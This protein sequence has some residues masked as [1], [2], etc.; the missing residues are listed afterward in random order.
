LQLGINPRHQ[1][2]QQLEQTLRIA[3][4]RF[5]KGEESDTD[6]RL[7]HITEQLRA[8]N[9]LEEAGELPGAIEAARALRDRYPEMSEL[10]A[11]HDSIATC[12]PELSA[13]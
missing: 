8:I 6:P 12:A 10:S 1:G 7:S 9:H 5:G 11:L 4:A 2:A 13:R 3:V